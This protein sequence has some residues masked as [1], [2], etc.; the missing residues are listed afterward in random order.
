LILSPHVF[1]SYGHL[2]WD[3]VKEVEPEVLAQ[4]TTSD[5]VRAAGDTK[6]YR[7]FPSGDAGTKR[8]IPTADIFIA[9]SFDWDAVYEINTADRDAYLAGADCTEAACLTP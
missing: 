1:A 5:L 4:Y 9:N 8:W 2:R 7:L 6:V 3:R